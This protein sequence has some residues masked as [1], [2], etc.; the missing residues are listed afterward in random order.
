[1]RC[2]TSVCGPTHAKRACMLGKGGAKRHATSCICERV[3]AT[4][5]SLRVTTWRGGLAPVMRRNAIYCGCNRIFL[6]PFL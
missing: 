1:M 6:R 3:R 4:A 5:T 2:G